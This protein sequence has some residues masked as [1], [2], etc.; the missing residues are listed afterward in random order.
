MTEQ[1]AAG[2]TGS[3]R[4]QFA[5][6]SGVLAAAA[7]LLRFVPSPLRE[8]L[9]AV[10][11]PFGGK[12][13][14]SLRYALLRS[15]CRKIGNNVYVGQNVRIMNAGSLSIGSNVSIHANCYIDAVGTCEIG[16]D[17]SIAHASSILTFEHTWDN[18]QIP[19]KYN[20]TRM[21]PVIIED[22]CWIGCGVRILSG[23]TIGKRSV[24]AAGAVA[25]A[26]IPGNSIY[27][28]VPARFIKSTTQEPQ[29]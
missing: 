25:T 28:G 22:D 5:R 4:R 2:E 18:D 10:S 12:I 6:Y 21:S 3:G 11:N 14:L 26:S 19:I 13:A 23:V 20:P 17:V 9:W 1:P 16:N 15:M 29:T 27:G 8:L 7:L 24:V